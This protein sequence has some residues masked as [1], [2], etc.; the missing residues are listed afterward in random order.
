[1]PQVRGK[2]V[3]SDAALAKY[4]LDRDTYDELFREQG[5]LCKTCGKWPIQVID[6]C[7]EANVFRGL[8]CLRCNVALGFLENDAQTAHSIASYLT[9]HRVVSDDCE[10]EAQEFYD[11]GVPRQPEGWIKGSPWALFGYTLKF[12]QDENGAWIDITRGGQ[13]VGGI[14]ILVPPRPRAKAEIWIRRKYRNEFPVRD[15]GTYD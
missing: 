5:G 1:M 11:S 15:T 10:E 9:E 6:H 13:T 14:N 3:P 4:G 8:L 2:Y 7:H 12:G